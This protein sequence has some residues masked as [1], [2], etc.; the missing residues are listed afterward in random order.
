MVLDD[1]VQGLNSWKNIQDVVRVTLKALHSTVKVQG[2]AIK[3][4]EKELS[5]R[6]TWAD[7]EQAVATRASVEDVSTS[8][9]ELSGSLEGLVSGTELQANLNAAGF[10]TRTDVEE[11]I[12]KAEEA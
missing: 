3:R 11:S 10:A 9:R 4:L 7:L 2:E 6:P 8:F 12:R 1:L 5:E